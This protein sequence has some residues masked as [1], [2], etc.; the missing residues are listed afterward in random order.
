M[1]S[2]EANIGKLGAFDGFFRQHSFVVVLKW[3]IEFT[4]ASYCGCWKKGIFNNLRSLFRVI[5][6]SYIDEL[7]PHKWLFLLTSSMKKWKT[8]KIFYYK[9]I[10]TL[11]FGMK[12]G[13]LKSSFSCRWWTGGWRI[14][15]CRWLGQFRGWW[16]SIW[17]RIG[18]FFVSMEVIYAEQR[19]TWDKILEKA[20]RMEFPQF[21]WFYDVS[22]QAT[23]RVM[24]PV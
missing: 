7:F 9:K 5:A 10:S 1:V 3:K 15:R 12:E 4:S 2:F 19:R 6:H 16:I 8:E 14:G 22:Y 18:L 13:S 24:D 17:R 11:Y 20:S 21:E 23:G